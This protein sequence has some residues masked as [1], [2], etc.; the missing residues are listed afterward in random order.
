MKNFR[1]I[2]LLVCLCLGSMS[3]S[4][5]HNS[6]H[7]ARAQKTEAIQKEI[8]GLEEMGRQKALKGD[9][10]WDDLMA[11]KAYLIQGDGTIMVYQKGQN[12][13]SLPLK[14]FKLSE[15]IVRVYGESAVT[16]GLSEVESE[17][18]QHRP[19]S[20]QMR[21]LNVWKK[22]GKEWKIVAAERTLVRP[23]TK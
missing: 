9:T 1:T 21:F 19:F 2:S 8:L 11:D 5:Q 13:A 4:A 3:A 16:T 23:Y 15:M 14:S 7:G 6:H 17:T 10:G 20:F 22:F 12:L 18:P